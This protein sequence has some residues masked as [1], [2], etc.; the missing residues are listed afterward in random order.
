MV[1]T[2]KKRVD[3]DVVICLQ[4]EDGT[5]LSGSYNPTK[6]LYEIIT[7]M[8][9]EKC[10]DNPVVIYMRNEVYGDALKTESL[11]SLGVSGGR[12]LLRLINSDPESLKVQ[13]NVSAPLPQKPRLEEP[14]EKPKSSKVNPGPSGAFQL[15]S[16][17]QL[18]E[19]KVVFEEKMEVEETQPAQVAEEEKTKVKE[20]QSKPIESEPV[21]E[22]IP[23]VPPVINILDQ[24]GTIIFS[25]DS[26]QTASMDLPDSFFE[27]TESDVRLLYKELRQ[28]VDENENT[29]LMTSEFRKLEENKKILNQ[30]ATYKNCA[31]RIQLPNRHVIQTKFSTVETVGAVMDFVKEFLVNPE[32]NFYLFL[33]PPKTILEKD[34]TLVESHCVPSALLH[35]GTEENVTDILKPEFYEKL[36]SG[37]GASRVLL[38]SKS[39]VSQGEASTSGELTAKPSVPKNFME[40][41]SSAK[42]SGTIPKWFKKS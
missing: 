8:C 42:P 37:S 10:Q 20:T 26:L 1:E 4:L 41:K 21:V 16:V 28:Q 35:F 34:L 39:D 31:I 3:E 30:L 36:S 27:L 29:P 14:E 40:S 23:E 15:K 22:Q 33:T 11:K 6:T 5:R 7:E 18:K 32:I 13:A 24:R 2:D 17:E 25:L 38:S 12:V 9:P 19:K